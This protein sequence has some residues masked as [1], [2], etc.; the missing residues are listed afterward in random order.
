MAF[1]S[2][3]S[4]LFSDSL[5][6]L[7]CN[8][9]VSKCC[10]RK[11]PAEPKRGG[12]NLH[13]KFPELG[14]VSRKLESTA[15]LSP[16]HERSSRIERI[17]MAGMRAQMLMIKHS[18]SFKCVVARFVKQFLANFRLGLQHICR[19]PARVTCP[20]GQRQ[21][22]S[23]IVFFALKPLPNAL[24][25]QE[26]Q[27]LSLFDA[28]VAVFQPSNA[29]DRMRHQLDARGCQSALG[30][31]TDQAD[32]QPFT[33]TPIVRGRFSNGAVKRQVS[34]SLVSP[35]CQVD[36]SPKPQFPC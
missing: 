9:R 6:Q 35:N 4:L 26:S 10:S 25:I 13:Y 7:A 16:F 19:P 1:V 8:P 3:Y 23:K 33:V 21:I 36:R 22:A 12:G 20:L 30:R 29:Q 31:F 32:M 2:S 14:A 17:D 5:L 18:S 24:R 28:A 11:K 15:L 27:H 34:V